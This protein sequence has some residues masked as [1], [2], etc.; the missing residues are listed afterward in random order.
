MTPLPGRVGYFI[1]FFLVSRH[2]ERI[3]ALCGDF[4]LS[5]DYGLWIPI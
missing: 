5:T 4:S 1:N 2:L 3:A